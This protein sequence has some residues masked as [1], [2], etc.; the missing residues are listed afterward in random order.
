MSDWITIE[1]GS[2][3]LEKEI[4]SVYLESIS[5]SDDDSVWLDGNEEYWANK[6]EL[7]RWSKGK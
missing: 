3:S 1:C 2:Y 5:W 4:D 7:R 6:V